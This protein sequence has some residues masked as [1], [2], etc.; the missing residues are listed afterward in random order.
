MEANRAGHVGIL[1][2]D[3]QTSADLDYSTTTAHAKVRY[4]ED[5]LGTHATWPYLQLLCKGHLAIKIKRR[6]L[7][8]VTSVNKSYYI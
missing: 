7:S 5:V 3:W 2:H 4:I 1:S 8:T 6:A